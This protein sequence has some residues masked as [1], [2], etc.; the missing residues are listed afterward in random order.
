LA[1]VYYE[2]SQISGKKRISSM[3]FHICYV[4]MDHAWEKTIIY[5]KILLRRINNKS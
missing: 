2:F 3:D 4:F 1:I 5:K